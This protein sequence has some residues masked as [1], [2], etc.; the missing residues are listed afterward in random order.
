MR[1]WREDKSPICRGLGEEAMPGM[2]PAGSWPGE[3]FSADII[4][5]VNPWGREMAYVVSTFKRAK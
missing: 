1:L 3:E 2:L 5:S 4:A